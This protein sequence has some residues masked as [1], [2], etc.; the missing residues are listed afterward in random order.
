M[1]HSFDISVIE[2][3]ACT[4]AG[5]CV[6]TNVQDAPKDCPKLWQQD[7]MPRLP[8]LAWDPADA[9]LNAT[10]GISVMIGEEGVFDYWAAAPL[11]EGASVPEGMRA[12]GLPGGLYAH[13][14]VPSM[15]FLGHAYMALYKDWAPQQTE[16][17]ALMQ[18]PCV[19]RY[20]QDYLTTGG[21]DVYMPVAK[22]RS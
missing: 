19:E 4:L 21:F 3:P 10:F 6:R 1:T 5:L 18:A 12:I 2:V 15:D 14:H 8:E 7:F 22:R 11:A 20:T 16:Y 9:F 17:E 13:C